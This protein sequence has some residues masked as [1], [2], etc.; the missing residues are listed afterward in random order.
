RNKRIKVENLQNY[1]IP[2]NVSVVREQSF[3]DIKINI[4]PDN[5][6]ILHPKENEQIDFTVTVPENYTAGYY[7]GKIVMKSDNS[8]ISIPFALTLKKSTLPWIFPGAFST[9]PST[10]SNAEAEKQWEPRYPIESGGCVY[11]K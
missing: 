1:S 4:T 2:V 11:I 8:S 5:D 3:D 6:F 7:C 10:I 9:T